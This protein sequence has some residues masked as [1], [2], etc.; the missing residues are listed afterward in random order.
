MSLFRY[1]G[2]KSKKS[3]R[4]QILQHQPPNTKEY[5]EPFVGGGGIFFH[6]KPNISRW[7]N[8]INSDLISVYNALKNDPDT[9]INQCRDIAPPGVDEPEVYP[10]KN[11][12][13]RKYNERLKNKFDELVD[14]R[15]RNPAL[16]YFF[17]N[18][19]VWAGRVNYEQPSR[20]Y[21]SNPNGWNI[22]NTD[23]LERAAE[24]LSGARITCGD[25]K[26]VLSAEGE[27]VWIYCDP[28]YMKDTELHSMSKQYKCGFTVEDHKRFAKAVRECKHKI[29]ISYDDHEMIRSLFPENLFRIFRTSWTYSGTSSAKSQGSKKKRKGDELIITNYGNIT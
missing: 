13:G 22:V 18:R 15:T 29:C 20:L 28:P 3:I 23:R 25:Y 26:T 8:D 27:D 17:I 5:R 6:I 2:G 21:F 1:P 16:S 24:I 14:D 7:I 12:R 4:E 19:T 10:K 9:F 11:S